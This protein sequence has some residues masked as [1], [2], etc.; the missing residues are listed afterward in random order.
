MNHFWDYQRTDIWYSKLP[1]RKQMH[2]IPRSYKKTHWASHNLNFWAFPKK[3]VSCFLLKR[4]SQKL[5]SHRKQVYNFVGNLKRQRPNYYVLT[6]HACIISLGVKWWQSQFRK[7]NSMQPMRWGSMHWGFSVFCLIGE[8]GRRLGTFCY[9]CSQFVLYRSQH[10]PN[11]CPR[12]L[13][14]APHFVPYRVPHDWD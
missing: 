5:G 8:G 14:I 2:K 6:I 12:L 9:W 10:V 7:I 13:P 11:L 3:K 1:M 4:K